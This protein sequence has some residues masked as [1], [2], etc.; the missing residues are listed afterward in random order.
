M[1]T[2]PVA[3]LTSSV[4]YISSPSSS[5]ARP[6]V[7]TTVGSPAASSNDIPAGLSAQVSSTACSAAPPPTA[8]P[9]TSSPIS[10][11]KTPSPTA[12]TTPATSEC[13]TTGSRLGVV[14][15]NAPER[16]F[17]S[18]GLTPTAR[19][20]MRTC[21]ADGCGSGSSTTRMTIDG[22]YS[23]YCIAL[24]IRSRLVYETCPRSQRE[25]RPVVVQPNESR[26]APGPLGGCGPAR[27]RWQS[28]VRL[29]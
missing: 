26:A 27:P 12:S 17:Q 4:W 29:G 3:P 11:P 24:K 22:P 1:P 9:N 14:S 15:P 20:A 16:N 18:N 7:S 23:E 6:A 8:T 25:P 21:P 28:R 5:S 10:T 13:G 19:T 2:P